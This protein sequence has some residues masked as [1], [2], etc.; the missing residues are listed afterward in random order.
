MRK[1]KNKISTLKNKKGS[2]SMIEGIERMANN[3]FTE[4]FS[5]SNRSGINE[6]LEAMN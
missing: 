6:A 4:L 1:R 2:G 3:Y 5:T